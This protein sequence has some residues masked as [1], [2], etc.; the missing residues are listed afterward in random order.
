MDIKS[1]SRWDKFKDGA[2]T[3]FL[4]FA[5]PFIWLWSKLASIN[6][7]GVIFIIGIGGWLFG[8]YMEPMD[9][10]KILG[11]ALLGIMITGLFI[12][13]SMNEFS[14]WFQLWMIVVGLA[15][16]WYAG[17]THT[18]VFTPTEK[19]YMVDKTITGNSI[20][21]IGSDKMTK[22]ITIN[23]KELLAHYN[24]FK[25]TPRL[26]TA[27]RER[28]S[29]NILLELVGIQYEHDLRKSVVVRDKETKK[30][31]FTIK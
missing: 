4:L 27:L 2:I 22:V 16:Y 15:G 31:I 8:L 26:E 10:F 20:S 30:I 6:I 25:D 23:N 17:L 1:F 19:V 11:I 21:Y 12:T 7:L 3:A 24:R 5:L 29:V 28:K 13:D 14:I 9:T 18:D